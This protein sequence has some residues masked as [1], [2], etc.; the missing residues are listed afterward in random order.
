[1]K[2]NGKETTFGYACFMIAIAF[3][4]SDII[5]GLVLA[6]IDDEILSLSLM[7]GIRLYL[8]IICSLVILG[9]ALKLNKRTLESLGMKKKNR[10]K[11]YLFGHGIGFVLLSGALLITFLLKGA[12][13]QDFSFEQPILLFIIFIGF[14]FQG[15]EE[16]LMCR[17][18]MMFGL[19]KSHSIIFSVMSNS[20]FFAALHIGNPNVN[21][22]SL[23]NLTLAGITFSCLALYFDDIWAASG[24][25]SMW[26]FAQGNIYGIFVSGLDMGPR[27]FHF[28][29][30]GNPLISGGKFGLEGGVGVF[31]IEM[32]AILVLYY[33][34][35]KKYLQ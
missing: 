17:G 12:L 18:F 2:Q 25:H 15:F 1:M 23:V 32:L 29:L 33:F 20:L 24:A 21:G 7:N 14:M 6:L 10:L 16:E 28:T 11:H 34:F 22:L 8:T 5:Q 35:Q 31:I 26:N 4:I 27:I 9:I 30:Q 3:L 19:C 13:Y